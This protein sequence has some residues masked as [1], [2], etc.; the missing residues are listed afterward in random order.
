MEQNSGIPWI[1]LLFSQFLACVGYHIKV[2]LKMR[3]VYN[4]QIEFLFKRTTISIIK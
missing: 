2:L 3:I 1:S 4:Q